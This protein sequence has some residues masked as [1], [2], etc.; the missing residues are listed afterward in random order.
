METELGEQIVEV[1]DLIEKEWK[2]RYPENAMLVPW[3]DVQMDERSRKDFGDIESLALSIK[4]NG[5]IHPP[6]VARNG[7]GAKPWVLVGGERRMKAM[8][9]LGVVMFPVNNREQLEAHEVFELE[10]MENFHR[11]S[12]LWQ[13]QC[14]LICKTHREK[15]RQKTSDHQPWGQKETGY[16]LGVSNAHVSHATRLTPYLLR[17]DAEVIACSSMFAAYEVLLKRAENLAAEL[18]VNELNEKA[19]VAVA[20][21][22]GIRHT[23]DDVDDIFG[24]GGLKNISTQFAGDAEVDE[25]LGTPV[26]TGKLQLDL[27]NLFALGDCLEV[28]KT[29]ETECVDHI[30]TDPPYGIDMD[31][32]VD[33]KNIET[34]VD[35]HDV[36]Q[37]VSMFEPF[38]TQA[39]RLVKPNGYCV[40][41]YDLDHHEKLQAIAGKVGFKVQ[42]WPIIWHKLHPCKNASPRV[43]FTK[44]F[45]CAM[46]LRKSSGTALVSTQ[47]SCV[48][49][50]DGQADRKL[51]DNPFAKPLVAWKFILEAI[52]YRG[53]VIFDPYAG[54]MSCARACINLGMIPRGVELDPDHYNKGIVQLTKLLK[55]ING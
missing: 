41:W 36:D 35:T 26:T 37:N 19:K 17:G 51:Y 13:E 15:V 16:L 31:N 12:M 49:A 23:T 7:N 9:M 11:K 3:D 2:F 5:L 40:F 38:L 48:F 45:E 33:M 30:V 18:S 32:L 53:Q 44:N 50:G 14:V 10:L 39:F 42:R 6:T 43:N 47:T 24:G 21:T 4:K 29:M 22:G 20:R 27:T 34:V 52:A 54:Q 46:V 28:M 55:E 8:Q 25:F 1:E